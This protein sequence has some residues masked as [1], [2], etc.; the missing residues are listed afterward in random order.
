MVMAPGNQELGREIKICRC[1]VRRLRL[2]WPGT[3][4]AW[5]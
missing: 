3:Q 4:E 1:A 5:R 2:W